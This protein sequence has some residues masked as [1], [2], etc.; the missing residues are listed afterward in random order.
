MRLIKFE[1][2]YNGSEWID[3]LYVYLDEQGN[4]LK[5]SPIADESMQAEE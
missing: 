1:S 5:L 2:L 4:I 3:D